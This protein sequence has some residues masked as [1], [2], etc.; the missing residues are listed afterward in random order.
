MVNIPKLEF[1]IAVLFL[2]LCKSIQNSYLFSKPQYC[3]HWDVKWLANTAKQKGKKK[4]QIMETP[5]YRTEKKQ[6]FSFSYWFEGRSGLTNR[7]NPKV[8]IEAFDS[9]GMQYSKGFCH[10]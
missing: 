10:L 8:G 1:Q 9:D 2:Q 3:V 4:Y 5:R 6:I 7:Y